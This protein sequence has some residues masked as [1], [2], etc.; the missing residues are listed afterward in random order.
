[1][2]YHMFKTGDYLTPSAFGSSAVWAGKPPL[3]MWLMAFSYQFLGVNNIS[4]RIW[5]P[6]FATLSLVVMFYLGKKLYNWQ[7]GLASAIVLGTFTTFYLFARHAMTD[8]PSIFFMLASMYFMLESQGKLK[9]NRFVALSGGF[10]WFRFANKAGSSSD[11]SNHFADL[12]CCYKEKLQVSFQKKPLGFLGSYSSC[13]FALVN[14]YE[15][16]VWL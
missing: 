10:L 9:P 16:E 14:L 6:F 13:F 4:A 2:A 5:I 7:V 15:C 3:T 11:Y 1:M 12:F 8:V